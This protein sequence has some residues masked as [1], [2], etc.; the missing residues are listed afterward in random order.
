M[1]SIALAYGLNIYS[2]YILNC[3][4]TIKIFTDAKS[5]IYAKRNSTHSILL[6]SA[7]IYITNFVSLANIE[8]YHIPGVVNRLADVMSRAISDNLQ[9]G[10]NKEHPLSKTW[11]KVLPPIQENFA[12]TRDA[13]LKIFINPLK[14]EIQDIHNRTQR[15]L[16]E[17]KSIQQEYDESLK[18]TPEHK[19][20]CSLRLLSI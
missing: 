8:I 7:I 12:V 4:G 19:Y 16:N 9:C 10:L 14:P 2:V 13:L 15:R 18:I 11:A 20:Y 1:E 6:N 3:H 17:P 5:L